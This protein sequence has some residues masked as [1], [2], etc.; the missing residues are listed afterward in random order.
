MKKMKKEKE[1]EE[2]KKEEI[3]EKKQVESIKP[4]KLHFLVD[5]QSKKEETIISRNIDKNERSNCSKGK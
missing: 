1:D 2:A 3:P 5:L 4:E